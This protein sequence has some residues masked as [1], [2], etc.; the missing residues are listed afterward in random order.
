MVTL[1]KQT[2]DLAHLLSEAVLYARLSAS[3]KQIEIELD[4]ESECSLQG[5]E[6]KLQQVI[7][8]LL[9]NA[10]KFSWPGGQIEVAAVREGEEVRVSVKDNG[11]GIPEAEQAN[12]FRPFG[13]TSVRTTKGE[14]STGLGLA[15]VR[16]IVEAHGGKIWVTSKQGEGA[17]FT[18]SLPL[19]SAP[20]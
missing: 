5:D 10:V 20:A 3:E 9:T 17:Q 14:S 2:I 4:V 11:Q 12:L 1:Q 18:F 16:R 8:N 7:S 13:K 19:V 6:R 15:I